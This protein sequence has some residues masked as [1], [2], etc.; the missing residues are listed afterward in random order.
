MKPNQHEAQHMSKHIP[1]LDGL[2]GVSVLA[3]LLY[4]AEVPWLPGGFLGV[5]MFFVLSGFLITALLCREHAETGAIDLAA[6]YVRRIRRLMPALVTFLFA[7]LGYVWLW[8][9]E[10]RSAV[11][12]DG[13][14]ALTYT[15]NAHLVLGARSYFEEA[16]RPSLLKHLWSLAVEEQFYLL[17]PPVCALLFLRW[18]ARRAAVVSVL[19]AVLSGLRMAAV[20][21]PLRDPSRAY[22]GTDSHAFGLLL[23]AALAFAAA[24]RPAQVERS[25]WRALSV[26]LAGVFVLAAFA[27]VDESESY[28]FRGGIFAVSAAAA[29]LVAGAESAAPAVVTRALSL[30]PLVWL[31]EISYSLYLFHWPVCVLLNNSL[32]DAVPPAGRIAIAVSLSILL[33]GLSRELVELPFLRGTRVSSHASVVV[34]S[35]RRLSLAFGALL[36][37]AA[38]VL[39]LWSDIAVGN[40]TPLIADADMLAGPD[41]LPNAEIADMMPGGGAAPAPGSDLEPDEEAQ[42]VSAELADDTELAA[43]TPGELSMFSHPNGRRVGAQALAHGVG[44]SA[45]RGPSPVPASEFAEALLRRDCARPFGLRPKL[46]NTSPEVLAVGDS[47]MLGAA[48]SVWARNPRIEIDACVGRNAHA[49]SKM[50]TE[51]VKSQQLPGTVIVHIGNNGGLNQA[52]VDDMMRMLRPVKRICFV[53]T[54]VPRRSQERT[55]ALLHAAAETHDH[56]L[57]ADWYAHTEDGEKMF[58]Q[59]GVHLTPQGARSYADFVLKHCL[60]AR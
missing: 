12:L 21:D 5:D 40:T 16:L 24:R 33:A 4:H 20:F 27:T 53:T 55:N 49:A 29:V 36:S 37:V 31:G 54:R 26:S 30:R 45:A 59:D 14:S 3:V 19:L 10:E 23:G 39:L 11:A 60:D 17:Y 51:R 58:R 7:T 8:L 18:P 47:V 2:R 41:E 25:W 1:A 38:G 35:Q 13:L 43:S 48:R 22:Y 9:P 28:V 52:Q 6:F 32:R 46:A 50:L 56:V 15:T 34:Q 42:A 44:P 57:L